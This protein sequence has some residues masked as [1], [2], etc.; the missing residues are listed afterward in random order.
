MT[1]YLAEFFLIISNKEPPNN[2]YKKLNFK[3]QTKPSTYLTKVCL[4]LAT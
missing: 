3:K 4:D 2:F 1:A